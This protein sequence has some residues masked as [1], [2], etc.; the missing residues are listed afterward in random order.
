MLP[1]ISAVQAL[2]AAHRIPLNRV[3][4]AI[5]VTTGRR[6]AAGRRDGLSSFVVML[7]SHAGVAA[8][9]GRGCGDLLGGVSG[10]AGPAVGGRDGSQV[11]QTRSRGCAQAQRKARLDHG[12]LPDPARRKLSDINDMGVGAHDAAGDGAHGR[13]LRCRGRR[14][15]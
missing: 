3:G 14:W 2:A 7:D 15:R 9:R 5:T 6:V 8:V 12:Y 13:E 11:V 10:D 1:G 4:E